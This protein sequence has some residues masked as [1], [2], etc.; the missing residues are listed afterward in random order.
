MK[1]LAVS[2]A[3]VLAA[4]VL[5]AGARPLSAHRQA[6]EGLVVKINGCHGDV[7][8]DYIPE[9]GRRAPHYHLRGSCRPVLV[10]GEREIRRRPSADCHR[11][12]R[13][14]RVNGVMLRHR[15]VGDDCSIREVR[16]SS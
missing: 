4:S 16:S 8:D 7:R 13:T 15:H 5:P 10:E 12:V 9:I 6:S 11:D 3:A 1:M 2:L 14:H